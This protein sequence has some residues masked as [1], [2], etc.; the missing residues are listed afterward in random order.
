LLLSGPALFALQTDFYGHDD[1]C[2]A[3]STGVD[4]AFLFVFPPNRM[5]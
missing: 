1:H 3:Y 5:D 2:K 4:T